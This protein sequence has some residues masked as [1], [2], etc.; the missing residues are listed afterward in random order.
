MFGTSDLLDAFLIAYVVPSFA[1]NL[2]SGSINSALIPTYIEVREH[3]GHST[4]NKLYTSVMTLGI[5]F[6]A[7]CTGFI[8]L[9]APYY[10]Q[11]LASGFDHEKL[12]LTLKSFICHFACYCLKWSYNYP[13]CCAECW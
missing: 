11:I 12:K 7:I 4:A 1:I 9:F 2:I 3:S 13:R 6:L 5:L 8:V 10:L